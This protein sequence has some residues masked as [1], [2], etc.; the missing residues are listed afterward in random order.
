MT[1]ASGC[2]SQK[3]VLA[4]LQKFLG[5]HFVIMRQLI[6][7]QERLGAVPSLHDSGWKMQHK[8]ANSHCELIISV[9]KLSNAVGE[10]ETTCSWAYQ[11]A[12]KA[13]LPPEERRNLQRSGSGTDRRTNFEALE[14]VFADLETTNAHWMIRNE[15]K[16]PSKRGIE[17][18][19]AAAIGGA[20][21]QIQPHPPSNRQFDQL[22]RPQPMPQLQTG[23][24]PQP[25]NQVT[26]PQKQP[27]R[28]N[29]LNVHVPQANQEGSSYAAATRLLEL[30]ANGA[31]GQ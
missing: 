6:K 27:P 10:T 31:H 30:Q 1:H 17:P 2:N 16:K 24:T 3:E 19:T 20:E 28:L 22:A 12:L 7:A 11:D 29:P 5:Q 4:V 8:S 18:F 21:N 25:L 14:N 15:G 26:Y 13:V 9:K 23:T